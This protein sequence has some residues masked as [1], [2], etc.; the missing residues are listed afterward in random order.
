MDK[1]IWT[2][3]QFENVQ[4]G[5]NSLDFTLL[6]V[7]VVVLVCIRVYLYSYKLHNGVIHNLY[8]FSY[9]CSY[10]VYI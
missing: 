6:I 2:I 8:F 9:V 4:F 1:I 7:C 3:V 5:S 10:S